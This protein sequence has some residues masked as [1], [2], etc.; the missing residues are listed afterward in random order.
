MDA[1]Q[2]VSS[3]TQII[4]SMIGAV[5]ALELAYRNLDEA[6]KRIRSLEDFV[7][8][9]ENLTHRVKQ[10]HVYKLHNSQLDH[11]LQS[12]NT[13][14]ER[15]HPKIGKARRIMS[16]SKIKNLAQVVWT[17]MTGDPLGKL[18]HSIKDDLNWWL[19]SQILTQNVERV[20]EITAQEIPT[21]LKVKSEQGYPISSKCLFVRNLLEQESSQ[22]VIL[23]VGLSGIGKSCL[24]RQVASDPPA[25]FVGG[26]VELGFGQWCS[27]AACNGN[28]V[29]YEKRLARKISKF[30]VQI[31]FWKKINNDNSGDLEYLCCMLQEA[32]Y[33]K[34]TLI[35]L[36]DVWEQ[37][38]VERFAKLYD[39]D[40]KYLVTTRN[41]SVYEITEAEKVELSKDEIKEISKAILLYHCRLSGEEIPNL[42]AEGS[43]P[44][45]SY[46]GKVDMFHLCDYDDTSDVADC[47][48]ERCGH[49]PLTVAVMGKALRKEL[50]AEK[51]EKAMTNLS[52]YATCAEG[53][54]SYV[55]EKEAENT[56]TIF[57]SFEFSLEA[58]PEDSR[59]LFIALAA[60]SWAEP[61]P[62]AC[63][64][65]TWSVL[66][67]K[68]LFP[69]IVCKLVEGSLLM[70]VDTDPLYEVH[71]MVSLY[72]DSKINDSAEILL[73][74][75]KAE[76]TASI[77]PWLLIFGKE[78]IK[79]VA[80]RKIELSFSVLDEK[81]VIISLEAILEALMASKSISE[82]ET[83]RAS[84]SS[85][86]GPRIADLISTDSQSLTAMS[87]EAITNIFSKGDY[88]R[89]FP[90]LETTGA[91]DKLAGLLQNCDDPIIQINI[92]MVLSKLAEFGSP[93]TVDKVLQ[94]IRFDQL[95][96]L[97]SHNAQE[98][99]ECMFA[100]LM[101]L[102]KAGKSKAV[103]RMF[104]FEIEKNLIKLLE[105]GS[106]VVQHHAIVTLKAFYEMAGPPPANSS[107]RPANL[108]LL[109]WQVR[110]RLETFV[111]SDR[112]VPL[113]PKPQTLEDVIHR[114]LDGGNKQVL[115]A[116]QDL[117]P[118]LEKAD[119]PRIREM[120]LKGPL[121]ERLSELLQHVIPEQNLLR[122]GSSFLLTKL[123]C[124]G[125]EPCIKKYLEYDIIPLL[126]K[127]MQC[128][129]AELQDSAYTALHQMLFSNGGSLVLNKIFQMGLI[130]RMVQSLESKTKKT[131]EVNM[132][133]VVDIVELGNKACLARMLSLQVVEKLVKVEKTSGGSGETLTEFLKGMDKCKHLSI[134]ERKLM[135]QQVVRKVRAALKGHKFETKILAALDS[136]LSDGLKNS[137][138]SGSG[139][140]R[141]IK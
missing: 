32:L 84:F 90:S 9:L 83:S 105:N 123:A 21:R 50:R 96:E 80:K 49:H 39:N 47:L 48:L 2:V 26:A 136:C 135:K 126:V 94:S 42:V 103:E 117:I 89:H 6:P 115:E 3:A 40:C 133:C 118:F 53:P 27:R 5:G 139:K 45:V 79:E 19:E 125:G 34:S 31:G 70:K 131:R 28:K 8:D 132:H 78:N 91:V 68:S 97:L 30:L 54:S 24:A 95:A 106:E 75:S 57:G 116:M 13:L 38:I 110:L 128:G 122:S 60:L 51:W 114:V 73:N 72:L 56:L 77:C 108:R 37:D 102:I 81:Q 36:D 22:H 113:S 98:W 1:L 4:S 82:L 140:Y 35:L 69:L 74:E 101:S 46:I 12:L 138:S 61:V 63:V 20:I 55:N 87:A 130:E 52:T 93:E 127:M 112:R 16:R 111:L 109:P 43:I 10:K 92:F 18:V 23:I 121:I 67:Q 99:H 134:A 29:E 7:R 119:D 85:I 62:E 33:G 71:D 76:E 41:E 86:L 44:E 137:S 120:I 124:A 64:E 88:C 104:A 25:R 59:Q 15:L 66:G 17:S 129:A 107:L 100:I 11:Q 65:A 58:M 141:K 14:T